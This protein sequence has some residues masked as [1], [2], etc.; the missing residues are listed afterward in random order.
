MWDEGDLSNPKIGSAILTRC[1]KS[2]YLKK[3]MDNFALLLIAV[4]CNDL[5][6]VLGELS[7]RLRML[8]PNV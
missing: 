3:E 1:R 8:I 5:L 6:D 2:P 7:T 4:D